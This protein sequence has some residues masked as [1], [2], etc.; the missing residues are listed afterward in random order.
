MIRFAA[1]KELWYSVLIDATDTKRTFEPG[2]H[3]C[4]TWVGNYILLLQETLGLPKKDYLQDFRGKYTTDEE[5]LVL[6][7]NS[8]GLEACITAQ[9]GNPIPTLWG[10][11]G[12]VVLKGNC[13]GL[14]VGRHVSLVTDE[15][16]LS[17]NLTLSDKVWMVPEIHELIPEKVDE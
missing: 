10:L 2:V 12:C 16:V 4:A 5:G 7:M 15:E 17:T 3:D 11:D 14:L 6:A 9:L 8:G 1:S 13:V